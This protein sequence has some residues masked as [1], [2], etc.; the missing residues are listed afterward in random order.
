MII[1]HKYKFIFIKTQKTAGTSIEVFLSDLCDERDIITPIKP[2]VEGHKPRNYRGYFNCLPEIILLRKNQKAIRNTI[3]N[4]KKRRKFFN[5]IPGYLVRRRVSKS[6]WNNYF[7]FCVERNPW[8][9]T[10]SMYHMVRHRIGRPDL[11]F[12]DFLEGNLQDYYTDFQH[13]INYPCYMDI[14]GNEI[15]VDRVLKYEK[16]NEELKT[17]FDSLNV[18]FDGAL[19]VKAKSNWRKDRSDYRNNYTSKQK[20]KVA[21]LF[22][23]EIELHGYDF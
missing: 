10:L 12:D 21:K 18:P 23:K 4:L 14:S 17:V 2:L 3:E 22:Q 8:D 1:S 13:C 7:K 6:I 11:A 9:K 20:N 15:I 5:H 16:L 19:H